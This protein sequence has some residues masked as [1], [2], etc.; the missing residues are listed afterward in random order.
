MS[1]FK[2][3]ETMLQNYIQNKLNSEDTRQVELWLVDNPDEMGDLELD[4]MFKQAE[5]DPSE[6][7]STT[8]QSHF[9]FLNIFSNRKMLPI[10]I[11]TYALT[12]LFIFNTF[13]VPNNLQSS[14]ATFIELEKQRG[15]NSTMIE[16]SSAV[17]KSLVLRFFP[18]S[19]SKKY[20][21]VVESKLTSIKYD[22]KNLVA[23]EL[24]SITV[25]IYSEKNMHGEWEIFVV[26]DTQSIEQKFSMSIN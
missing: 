18:D 26:D 17:N 16:V 24:G 6:D 15:I 7:S 10:H 14:P 22:F 9:V 1:N 19:M 5:Y 25:S 21:L 4:L 3:N 20:S 8:N 12:A 2:P 11:L 23:D 13:K